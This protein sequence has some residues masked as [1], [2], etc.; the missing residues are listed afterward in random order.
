MR[1]RT[2]GRGDSGGASRFFYTPKLTESESKETKGRWPANVILDDTA[3][4]ILD[5]QSGE[6]RSPKPYADS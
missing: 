1:E 5:Q 2:P 3:A 6:S 4:A